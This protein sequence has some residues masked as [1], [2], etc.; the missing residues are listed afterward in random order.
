MGIEVLRGSGF[1][2]VVRGWEF[3]SEHRLSNSKALP[4]FWISRPNVGVPI[5]SMGFRGTPIQFGRQRGT[6]R[7]L[8]SRPANGELGHH[9]VDERLAVGKGRRG[10]GI[11]KY[12]TRPCIV[13]YY[14]VPDYAILYCVVVYCTYDTIQ[15]YAILLYCT[16]LCIIPCISVPRPLTLRE[17]SY[18]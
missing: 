12:C 9:G 7:R 6:S 14:I 15:Y 4:Y 5:V 16:E 8:A 13:L 17:N 1:V 2:V 3:V 18:S 11:W 10:L